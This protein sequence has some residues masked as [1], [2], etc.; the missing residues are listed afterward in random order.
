MNVKQ[1]HIRRFAEMFRHFYDLLLL[2]RSL[3]VIID[4]KQRVTLER[5]LIRGMPDGNNFLNNV[6][7]VTGL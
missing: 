5:Y 1:A 4:E 3:L 2:I 6:T 7:G